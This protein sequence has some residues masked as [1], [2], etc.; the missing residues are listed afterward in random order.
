LLAYAYPDRVGALRTGSRER[1]LL[2]SGSGA[3]LPA[4]DGLAGQP[5]LVAASLDAERREGRIFLAAPI[6]PEELRT[7]HAGQLTRVEE[8]GWDDRGCVAKKA[9][10]RFLRL[11]LS[12]RPAATPPPRE[13]VISLLL[14]EIRR[15]GP[16]ILNWNAAARELQARIDCLRRCQPEGLWPDLGEIE[17]LARLEQWLGPWLERVNCLEQ[18]GRLD[19]AAILRAGLDW[20]QQRE[21]DDLAPTHLQVPSGSRIRLEYRAGEPPVLAVRLQELFGLA[22]S[23][24]ICRDRVKIS[25]HLLSPAGRPVQI[26]TDLRNFWDTTYREIKKELQ[27][28]Y[29]RHHWP[30][31]PWAAPPTA[32]VKRKIRK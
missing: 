30:D 14:A 9:E 7:Y 24:R 23:P 6:T 18:L 16:E 15:R 2:A 11:P 1:Y 29:P 17:L 31:D 25:L 32:R 4:G 5:W 26:T 8:V 21:L 10:E 27:G 12:S 3:R 28:R 19:L 13:Q 20:R 22:E